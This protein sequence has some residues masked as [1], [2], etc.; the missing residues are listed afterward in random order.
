MSTKRN[1]SPKRISC[2][3]KYTV[4]KLRHNFNAH[5]FYKKPSSTNCLSTLPTNY[6]KIYRASP[7]LFFHYFAINSGTLPYRKIELKYSNKIFFL[8]FALTCLREFMN[9]RQSIP[10]AF[11]A[12]NYL[13][14]REV[15]YWIII[16]I[17]IVR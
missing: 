7:W 3:K 14:I 5:V 4:S 15:H 1:R 10:E 12:E 6:M 16:F 11:F 2:A 13:H 9:G 8:S 17:L